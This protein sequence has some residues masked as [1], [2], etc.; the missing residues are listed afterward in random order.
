M[1]VAGRVRGAVV[2]WRCAVGWEVWIASEVRQRTCPD[3]Q[4]TALKA[5]KYILGAGVFYVMLSYWILSGFV[6]LA[7]LYPWPP[8]TLGLLVPLV[9]LY[10]WPP[11]TLGLLVPLVSLY[12]NP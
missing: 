3:E 1:L 11:C 10:P 9:S 8:C 6:P 4:G 7:S 2:A 12:C 5:Q